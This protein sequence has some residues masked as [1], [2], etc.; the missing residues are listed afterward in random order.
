MSASDT[1]AG[2]AGGTGAVGDSVVNEMKVKRRIAVLIV[3]PGP[4]LLSSSRRL[5]LSR[6]KD[7]P[8]GQVREPLMDE[9]RTAGDSL[10][11]HAAYNMSHTQTKLFTAAVYLENHHFSCSDQNRRHLTIAE[12]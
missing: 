2:G 8:Q 4:G 10:R 5:P 12:W 7:D 3:K 6:E 11:R 9:P 1:G